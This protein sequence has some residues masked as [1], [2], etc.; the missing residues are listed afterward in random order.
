MLE[1]V[2]DESGQPGV[3]LV[4]HEMAACGSGNQEKTV[5]LNEGPSACMACFM[6]EFGCSLAELVD[7]LTP[8][9][10]V[11]TKTVYRYKPVEEPGLNWRWWGAEA[12]PHL[13]PLEW[14]G[15]ADF[16]GFPLPVVAGPDDE[17]ISNST[18]VNDN[19]NVGAA[20]RYGVID[21]WVWIPA[22]AMVRDNNNN[23][24]ELGMVLALSLI[25]I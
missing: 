1:Y 14:S 17:G 18:N 8:E 24:G 9:P 16:N 11:G 12:G 22:A 23:T 2:C 19:S 25:H 7:M 15:P 21:G 10:W 3:A 5:A 20:M 13:D 4:N 6:A